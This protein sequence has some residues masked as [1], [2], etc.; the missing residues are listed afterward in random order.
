MGG[1]L[2]RGLLGGGMVVPHN[3]GVTESAKPLQT[4][5]RD[6]HGPLCSKRSPDCAGTDLAAK[7]DAAF[8]AIRERRRGPP[9]I[10]RQGCKNS[11][12]TPR[13]RD[14]GYACYLDKIP[15]KHADYK[16][17]VIDKQVAPMHKRGIWKKPAHSPDGLSVSETHRR[18][19]GLHDGFRKAQPIL[20]ANPPY[21]LRH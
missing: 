11:T 10:A 3:D 12:A 9:R 2:A 16:R 19:E 17:E 20:R 15:G 5:R 7:R 18:P 21:E 14:P 1:A 13:P 4:S 6:D 8:R